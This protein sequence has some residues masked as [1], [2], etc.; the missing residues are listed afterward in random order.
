MNRSELHELEDKVINCQLL[1]IAIHTLESLRENALPDG[2]STRWITQ[3]KEE[4]GYQISQHDEDRDSL[5]DNAQVMA[6]LPTSKL[7]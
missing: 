1:H 5:L 7:R 6:S 2:L 3:M 4:A